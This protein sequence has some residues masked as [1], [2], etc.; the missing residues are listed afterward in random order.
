[1]EIN[2]YLQTALTKKSKK[3]LLPEEKRAVIDAL[4]AYGKSGFICFGNWKYGEI[5]EF[6]KGK[7]A[8]N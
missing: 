6:L 1:M 3:A 5:K 7:I 4:F 2:A 8:Y